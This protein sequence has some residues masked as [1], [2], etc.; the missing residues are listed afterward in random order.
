MDASGE[1]E[2]VT[3][4]PEPQRLFREGR[5]VRM[6]SADGS[7]S[8]CGTLREE[9]YADLV[10]TID[11]LD[12]EAMYPGPG[13]CP[14]VPDGRWSES[15]FSDS[16]GE[17]H[18]QGFEHAPFACWWYCCADPLVPIGRIYYYA[19]LELSG[20]APVFEDPYGDPLGVFEPDSVGV[21]S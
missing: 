19:V 18:L 12:P 7:R 8:Y 6:S 21:C 15:T 13:S 17:L 11:G 2:F 20:S 9:T 4:G 5:D 3:N 1:P 14:L 16:D 10:A